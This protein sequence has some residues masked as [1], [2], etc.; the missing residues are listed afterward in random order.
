LSL[1]SDLE[2]SAGGGI[3]P[4]P[5]APFPSLRIAWTAVIVLAL[6]GAIAFV[7]RQ[8]LALLVE[9][10]KADLGVSDTQIGLL[11]GFSFVVLYATAGIPLGFA[12]DR[13]SRRLVIFLGIVAW[14]LATVVS[15]LSHTYDQLL[16]ARVCVGLGEAALGP[17]AYSIMSD[18]FPKHRLALAFSVFNLGLVMGSILALLVSGQVITSA[19]HG[20]VFP[21]VGMRN[22]WQSTFIII[23]LPGL[24]FSGLIFLIPEPARRGRALANASTS[25]LVGFL[26]SRRG[27]L[28]PHCLGFALLMA[29]TY[30]QG[31]WAPVVLQRLYGWSISKVSIAIAIVYGACGIVGQLTNGRLVDLMFGRGLHDAHLRYYVGAASL[32]AVAGLITILAPSGV[33]FVLALAPIIVLVNFGGVA[34]AAIQ[35]VT[36]DD[37][38]GRMASIYLFVVNIIGV[39]LGPAGIAWINE[40]AF[41][42]PKRIAVSLG[43]F[44]GGGSALAAV[45]FLLGL[46]PM[47]RAV[48]AN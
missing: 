37:L 11:Q 16:L 22:V 39:S 34:A 24:L 35:V 48:A 26:R 5:G 7:D 4:G 17:A 19:A 12:V 23:G 2:V 18:L 32:I 8:V 45:F 9:P 38:R 41:D 13:Y 46:A 30:G 47:R 44:V 25:R 6:I 29:V 14:S 33:V 40:V 42:D 15:G 21:L 36:P 10:L 43:L 27:F 1:V 28:I 31:A 20:I 3:S